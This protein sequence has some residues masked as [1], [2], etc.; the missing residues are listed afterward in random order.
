MWGINLPNLQKLIKVLAEMFL[1]RWLYGLKV[2][3]Q[4]QHKRPSDKKSF[5]IKFDES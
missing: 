4:H 3:N 2:K 1:R 5:D